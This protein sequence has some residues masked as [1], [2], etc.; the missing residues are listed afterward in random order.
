MD[1]RVVLHEGEIAMQHSVG[2]DSRT[3]KVHQLA[4]NCMLLGI[5][6]FSL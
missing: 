2:L 5:F 1:Q 3:Q 6:Q 4:K